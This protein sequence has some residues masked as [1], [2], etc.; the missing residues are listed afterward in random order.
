MSL[1]CVPSAQA[2]ASIV[3]TNPKVNSTIKTLPTYIYIEFDGNLLDFADSINTLQVTD[4]KNKRVDTKKNLVGGA[5]LS[6]TLKSGI[7]QGRYMVSYR[8]VSEDGHPVT[9][10]FYFTYK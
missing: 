3:A 7:K 1:I 10:Y 4:S 9:G 2:H 8:I 5:R 6:T